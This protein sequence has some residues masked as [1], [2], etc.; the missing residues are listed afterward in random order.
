MGPVGCRLT[1]SVIS[2]AALGRLLVDYAH[3]LDRIS[4]TAG[5]R[6]INLQHY[7]CTPNSGTILR[8][9]VTFAVATCVVIFIFGFLSSDISRSASNGIV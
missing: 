2:L 3:Y 4:I 6:L 8:G 9:F 7:M 5:Y 1:E